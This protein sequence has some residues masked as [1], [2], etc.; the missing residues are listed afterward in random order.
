MLV[1]KVKLAKFLAIADSQNIKEQKS[2]NKSSSNDLTFGK[3]V[4]IF[5][6]FFYLLY[7][8]INR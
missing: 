2:E 3:L 8:I 5:T 7:L 1:D 4:I 6:I